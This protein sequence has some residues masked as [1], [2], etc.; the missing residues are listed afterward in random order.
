MIYNLGV[1]RKLRHALGR[2]GV[3]EFVAEISYKGGVS[4][5]KNS[6]FA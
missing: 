6:F 3:E 5:L 4:V 1:V 2:E